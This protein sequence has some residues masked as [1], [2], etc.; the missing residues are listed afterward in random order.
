MDEERMWAARQMKPFGRLRCE[1]ERRW[2]FEDG[3]ISFRG[4]GSESVRL[5]FLFYW[6]LLY[7]EAGEDIFS[8]SIFM[9]RMNVFRE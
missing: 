4:E 8:S 9:Y 7:I 3:R 1:G 6:K 2:E 5:Y